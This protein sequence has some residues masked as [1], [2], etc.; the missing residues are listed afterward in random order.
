MQNFCASYQ[1]TVGEQYN[2]LDAVPEE[3]QTK[4]LAFGA[5]SSV[6]PDKLKEIQNE[7]AK[8]FKTDQ[9]V[10]TDLRRQTEMQSVDVDN[11]AYITKLVKEFGWIDVDRFGNEASNIAF[12]IVQHSGQLPLMLAALPE[13]EK[14]FKAEKLKDA[15]PYALLYDRVKI[16]TCQKQRYGSQIGEEEDGTP[17]VFPLEDRANVDKLRKEIGMPPLAQY[18]LFFEMRAGKK[19][20]FADE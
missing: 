19:A 7:M 16:D 18:L 10:R 8:R 6:G 15:Q 1:D 17:F 14:D 12:L 20:K 4:P 9:A 2:K 13:I 11:A 3:M 5:Q